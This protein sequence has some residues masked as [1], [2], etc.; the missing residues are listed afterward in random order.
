DALYYGAKAVR[1]ATSPDHPDYHC[2]TLDMIEHAVSAVANAS[3]SYPKGDHERQVAFFEQVS[4]AGQGAIVALIRDI[5]GNPFRPVTLNPTWRTPA[6]TSLAQAAYDERHLPSGELD[7]QRL[8]ILAD[9]LEEAGCTSAEI[10]DHLR[11]PGPH[12]RGCW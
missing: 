8:A 9:A 6:V 10:L 7:T 12:V 3:P 11:S 1:E 2:G 4:G 5:I